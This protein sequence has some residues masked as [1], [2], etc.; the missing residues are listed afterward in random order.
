M[1]VD[2]FPML[3]CQTRA[4]GRAKIALLW[5]VLAFLAGQGVLA[6]VASRSHPEIRDPEFGFRLLRLREQAAAAPDRPLCLILGS[7]RTLSGICPPALPSW[8]NDR[9]DTGPTAPEPRFFN[10][11]QLGAGPVRELQ[12]LRRLLAAGHQPRWLLLEVWPPF[13]PQHGYWLDELHIMQQDLRPEDL[14]VV[15]RY[16]VNRRDAWEKLAFE[17]LLPITGLRSNL[18]ARCA[19]SL[20]SPDQR[21]RAG[22]VDFWKDGEPSGWRPWLEHGT[23]D[24]FR[25]RIAGVKAQTK[26]CLDHFFVSDTTDRAMHEILEEC[27]R[28]HI[29]AALILM[30]EHSELRGWYTPAVHEQ[31]NAY[32]DRLKREFEV[33]VFDTRTWVADDAFHDL[34]HMAPPAAAPYTRRLGRE[35]LLP[36]LTGTNH[37]LR[38]RAVR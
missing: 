24:D 25:A 27:R 38:L 5:G 2:G 20:L 35:L 21:W 28:R 7:S 13:W 30:P 16:F 29:Q 18:L 15:S 23:D 26:P 11:S 32:L 33:P 10:F 9:R 34:T 14:S 1:A 8:P 37:R 3:D 31:I 19:S 12:T 36:W 4:N 6:Y 17:T 22:R